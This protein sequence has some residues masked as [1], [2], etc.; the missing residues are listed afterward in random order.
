MRAAAARQETHAVERAQPIGPRIRDALLEPANRTCALASEHDASP[1][2][3]FQQRRHTPFA[4]HRKHALRIAAADKDRILRK[5]DRP[6][7]R[8][9]M[10]ERQIRRPRARARRTPRGTS[11]RTPHRRPVAVGI[12][13]TLR[14]LFAGLLEDVLL[15]RQVSRLGEKP[16]AA[17]GN[18]VPPLRAITHCAL[19]RGSP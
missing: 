12:I 15:E 19:R 8:R 17:D 13:N 4:P 7:I 2:R 3:L 1:G 6:Q 18:D 16:A 14:P 11:S 9:A 5:N 10:K